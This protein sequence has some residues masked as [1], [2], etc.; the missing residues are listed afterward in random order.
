MP[1]RDKRPLIEAALKEALKKTMKEAFQESQNTV[2]VITG[3]LKGSGAVSEY[4]NEYSI[5]YSI[6]YA[7]IVERDWAG[8]HIWTPA[9][10]KHNGTRVKGHY[11]NQPPREGKHFIENAMRKTFRG[12]SGVKS[13]FQRNFLEFLIEHVHPDKVTEE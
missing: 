2:P 8:G 4:Y 11:K 6:E 9:F 13:D 5:K 1:L 10:T 12:N 7:S 3:A